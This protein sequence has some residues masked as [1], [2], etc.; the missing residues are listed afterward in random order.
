MK[1]V[2][3]IINYKNKKDTYDC[4]SSLQ[5]IKRSGLDILVVVSNNDT[6]DFT[7]S[8]QEMKSHTFPVHII[9]NNANLGF[10]GGHNKVLSYAK[11]KNADA[12]VILNN[13]TILDP[14]VFSELVT[15]ANST[16]AGIVC[17]KIYFA[18]GHEFHKDR[19]QK[20]ELGK[21]IWYAGGYMDWQNG[22][23]HHTGVDQVDTGQFDKD[24]QTEVAT[25]CCML[26]K[27]EVLE[28]VGLFDERYFLYYEDADYS[29]RSLKKGFTIY[30]SSKAIVWHKNAGAAGGSGSLLQ[31]YYISRNRMLFGMSHA[32]LR[33]K[34]ALLRESIRLLMQ[35]RTWQ[36]RGIRDF[37]Q[38]KLYKGTYGEIA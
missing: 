26:I 29:V 3:S 8:D 9:N 33:T 27:K 37:Y 4:L 28:K 34:L 23:G 5:E 2:V 25:G 24:V 31:D 38:R 1:L 13:D 19:Y 15:T 30:Y 22:I 35:G 18:S 10:A 14:H 21:V 11:E 12:V 17:P 20:S 6:V 7:F 36:K 32:P 16:K